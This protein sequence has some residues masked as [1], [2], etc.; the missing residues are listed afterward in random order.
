MFAAAEKMQKQTHA[1]DSLNR[2]SAFQDKAESERPVSR[3]SS[4]TNFHQQRYLGNS[5][6]QS[7]AGGRHVPGQVAA[8]RSVA[9]IQR[10]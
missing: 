10:K 4:T 8:H 3:L 7:I 1:I 9:T 2:I 6:M 5:Y